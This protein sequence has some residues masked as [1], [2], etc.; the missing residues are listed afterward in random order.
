MS[1]TERVAVVT[2]A[3]RGIGFEVCRQLAQ[4]QLQVILT[5]RDESKGKASVRELQE[6]GLLN[7]LYHQLDITNPESINQLVSFIQDKFNRLDVLVNNAGI[8]IDTKRPPDNSIFKMKT[9]TLRTTLETNLYGPLRLCQ[10]FAPLMAERSYGRI[11]NVSSIAGQLSSMRGRHPSYRISKS[12][13]NA[14]TRILADELRDTHVLV[15][16]VCP[17]WVKS[18]LGGPNACR[19]LSEGA[20]TV[21]WLATLPDD[22]PTGL[23]FRD[24]KP[25]DW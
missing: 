16:A 22:G 6:E 3:N 21:V 11:V 8:C 23:F 19:D 10:A 17:G 18:D 15:N 20:D 2:G 25:L 4:K 12:A 5:S 13:V 9:D 14:L 1:L 7:L 24:R